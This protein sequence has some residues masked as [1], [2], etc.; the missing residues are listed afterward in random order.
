MAVAIPQ[1]SRLQ[2]ADLLLLEG[3]EFWDTLVLPD[4]TPR[5]DDIVHKVEEGDR[6]DLI[7]QQYYQDPILWWVIAW[8]NNLEIIPTDLKDGDNLLI[9]SKNFVQNRLIGFA[10][11]RST[12]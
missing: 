1:S 10:R 7:A 12:V 6:I 2:F 11:E 5:P 8:A 4:A 9:P 3:V